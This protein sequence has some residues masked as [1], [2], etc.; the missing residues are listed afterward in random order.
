M[1]LAGNIQEENAVSDNWMSHCLFAVFMHPKCYA[2][3]QKSQQPKALVCSR[4]GDSQ[5]VQCTCAFRG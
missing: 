3:G 1:Y 2:S 5:P 4:F